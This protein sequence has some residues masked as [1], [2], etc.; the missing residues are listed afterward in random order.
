MN[1]AAFHAARRFAETPFGRIAYLDQGHGPAALF[2]HGY[3]LNGFQW[4]GV[5]P[6]LS[7]HHRCI[8]PDFLGL[9]YTEVAAGQSLAPEAQLAMLIALLDRLSV[10][11]VD[12]IA[13]DSGGSIAQLFIT[14]YPK[15]ARS[16]LLTNC[17]VENDSPPPALR[18]VI[19]LAQQ[20]TWADEEFVPQL[21]DRA[22]ARSKDG[23]GG[24]CY[25]DPAHPTDEAIEVYYTPLVSSQHR[26]DLANQYVVALEPNPLAGIEAALRRSTVPTRIVWGTADPIFSQKSPG[27]LDRTLGNSRGVRR[28]ERMKLFWPEER[29]EVVIE[30]A[31]RLWGVA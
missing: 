25:A 10:T 4:R 3:P 6:A 23:I 26:K 20:G 27:Y 28:L 18:P 12:L 30:E 13:N 17:D 9:G 2:L 7:A 19:A 11:R 8:V 29:P 15:R 31:R 14:R 24:H 16:L 1:A 21:A 5:V 22:L